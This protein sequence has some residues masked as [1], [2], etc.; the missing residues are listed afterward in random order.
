MLVYFETED[1]SKY[2]KQTEEDAKDTE[3]PKGR[4]DKEK[5]LISCN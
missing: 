2:D 4:G 1:A 3:K 5:A